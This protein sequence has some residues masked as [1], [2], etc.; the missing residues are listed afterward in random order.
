MG[1]GE[2]KSKNN[3]ERLKD[4]REFRNHALPELEFLN[5]E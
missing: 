5:T 1:Q 2:E 3:L 4:K